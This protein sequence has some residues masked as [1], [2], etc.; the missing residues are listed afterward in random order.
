MSRLD[1][2]ADYVTKLNA[3][4]Y[5]R[6]EVSTEIAPQRLLAKFERQRTH[7]EK[8]RQEA[9]TYAPRSSAGDP[10]KTLFVGRLS[11]DTTERELKREFEAEFGP[12]ASVN[13][14]YDRQG[15]SR[16]YAFL[17]F[18]SEK[19]MR[20][21]YNNANGMKIAGRRILVDIERSRTTPGWLPR[22]FG[23]GR[24]PGRLLATKTR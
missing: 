8:M 21:A 3:N 13:L 4:H 5:R 9:L 15:R 19:D 1:G 24:G 18:Q 17:E 11:Y 20:S 12:V 10:Y 2:L 23:G 22:R 7:E 6:L 16:G 14:V